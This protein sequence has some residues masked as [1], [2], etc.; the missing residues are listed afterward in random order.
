MINNSGSLLKAAC[1]SFFI[2]SAV[3]AASIE[4]QYPVTEQVLLSDGTAVSMPFRISGNLTSAFL[5]IIK[6]NQAKKFIAHGEF[7][8]IEIVCNGT[9]TNQSIGVL[10]FQD[11]TQSPV[12]A[13]AETV[14]TIAVKRK[15][16]QALPLPCLPKHASK[17]Q[18]MQYLLAAQQIMAQ[19]NEQNIQQ[20]VPSD[21][22]M[23]NQDLELNNTLAI[24]AG[25]EIWGY[26]KS[27]AEINYWIGN[28]YVDLQVADIPDYTPIV[29]LSYLRNIGTQTPL[30]SAG[31]NVL[32]QH[33]T[34]SE[35]KAAQ[36][37]GILESK[38]GWVQPFIG[39]FWVGPSRSNTAIA[40]KKTGFYPVAIVEYTN[41]SGAALALYGQ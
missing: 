19:A 32:P 16:A 18:Q 14:N 27:L 13:Y 9:G 30:Y 39:Y 38:S 24:K 36:L 17:Q 35:D 20:G 28:H 5:S 8:P 3:N 10:Y 15:S 29:E 34:P 4:Q 26:P 25:L 41:V 6:T 33:L 11:I 22:A 40:L 21:Y 12:G 31:D 1:A 2:S 37:K 23:Y 7:E